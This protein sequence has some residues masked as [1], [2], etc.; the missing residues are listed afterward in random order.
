MI[1]TL[2]FPNEIEASEVLIE[3]RRFLLVD[4][5]AFEQLYHLAPLAAPIKLRE[6]AQPRKALREAPRLK[7]TPKA[8]ATPPQPARAAGAGHARS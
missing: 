2:K 1:L 6:P 7:R 8:A 3:N 4:A 5:D